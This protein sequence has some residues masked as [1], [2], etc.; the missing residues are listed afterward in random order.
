MQH[1]SPQQGDAHTRRRP[2]GLGQGWP[3]GDCACRRR[4]RWSTCTQLRP[5]IHPGAQ[6]HARCWRSTAVAADA[7][8][9]ASASA[10]ANCSTGSRPPAAC[11]PP[12][13]PTCCDRQARNLQR[14]GRQLPALCTVGEAHALQ[15][16]Q[17]AVHAPAG[18]RASRCVQGT[19]KGSAC[20]R[21][22]GR[23]GGAWL[24]GR[25]EG[26]HSKAPA[27]AAV[28]LTR[29][30]GVSWGHSC[31]ADAAAMPAGPAGRQL[32]G[33]CPAGPPAWT[34]AP[35]GHHHQPSAGP[36]RSHVPCSAVQ[37]MASRQDP[38]LSLQHMACW[39]RHCNVPPAPAAAPAGRRPR[40]CRPARPRPRWAQSRAGRRRRGCS[41]SWQ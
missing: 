8:A 30:P 14:L 32:L 18:R 36:F 3:Q 22:G 21:A 2:R 17:H 15:A 24:A 35:A 9:A 31:T 34:A 29:G 20:R 16:S 40:G 4:G 38:L 10:S 26:R 27:A 5:A 25:R 19:G 33:S 6:V 39:R 37:C 13:P 12:H 41:A 7:A 23:A 28:P 11:L 1:T